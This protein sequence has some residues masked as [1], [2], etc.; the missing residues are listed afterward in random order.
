MVLMITK[1][2]I[3]SNFSKRFFHFFM[4]LY[5]IKNIENRAEKRRVFDFY[6]L[7][8]KYFKK[9]IA[10]NRAAKGTAQAR[11]NKFKHQC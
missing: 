9:N 1:V 11:T 2:L 8:F 3:C 6:F 7:K 5:K 4:N 10:T